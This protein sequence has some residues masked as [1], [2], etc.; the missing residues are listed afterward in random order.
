MPVL[1]LF[2][3]GALISVLATLVVTRQIELTATVEQLRRLL[4]L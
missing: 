2:A 1:F 3:L 4:R